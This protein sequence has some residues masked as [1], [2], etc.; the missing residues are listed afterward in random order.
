MTTQLVPRTSASDLN[1]Q[2]EQ[3][4]QELAEATDKAR[5]SEEMIRYLDFCAKFHQYSA[6][7]VWLILMAK[8][9]A[10]YVAGFQ[11]WKSLGRWVKKGE[12]GI[13]ILAP[14]LVKED[15]EEAGEKQ[16]LVGFRVVHVFDLTQTD[17]EPIPL[18]P[19][20]KSPEKKLR[21]QRELIHFAESKGIQVTIETLAGEIQGI[22]Q[23]GSIVLSPNAGT[24]TLV[25]E[26]SHVLL[27]FQGLNNLSRAE[28]ELEAESV[29]FIVSK[30][31]GIKR[32]NSPNYLALNCS[33]AVDILGHSERIKMTAD[34]IIRFI[35][36]VTK[37]D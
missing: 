19:N 23:G 28:K 10:S 22:S 18:V 26:I 3:H 12:R 2:I 35:E 11:K 14:I 31:F 15:E 37:A 17:G 5:T 9:E 30:H 27:H 1:K 29:A 34:E 36:N 6:G 21:L 33:L 4:L 25:H 32:I 24:K 8:P 16:Y 7:N 20:W 13:P